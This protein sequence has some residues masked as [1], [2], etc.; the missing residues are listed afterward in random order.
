MQG[1]VLCTTQGCT[2]GCTEYSGMHFQQK[3]LD[4]KVF[5]TTMTADILSE[6]QFKNVLN[7]VN[8]DTDLVILQQR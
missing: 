6:S 7:K 1:R 4:I 2:Q 3:R 8:C 5:I